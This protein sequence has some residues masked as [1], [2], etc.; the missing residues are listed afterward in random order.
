MNA[1]AR[2]KMNDPNDPPPTGE[3][4]LSKQQVP[5]R[6]QTTTNPTQ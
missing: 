5:I 2:V 3:I 1:I 6:T 4:S